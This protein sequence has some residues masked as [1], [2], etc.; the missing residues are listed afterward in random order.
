ML[1]L[2]GAQDVLEETDQQEFKHKQDEGAKE[3]VA[4]NELWAELHE[5]STKY[6]KNTGGTSCARGSFS[7]ASSKNRYPKECPPF[8]A[9]F[10]LTMMNDFPPPGA[11]AAQEVVLGRWRLYWPG[12]PGLRDVF[13]CWCGAEIARRGMGGFIASTKVAHARPPACYRHEH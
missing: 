1:S 10:T 8:D 7:G 9:S 3:S 11:R 6:V 12:P 5:L 4:P 2:E 13:L